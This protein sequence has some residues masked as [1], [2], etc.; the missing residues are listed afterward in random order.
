MILY[1]D[2]QPIIFF[3]LMSQASSL[4]M[5]TSSSRYWASFLGILAFLTE[6]PFAG[7]QIRASLVLLMSQS[8]STCILFSKNLLNSLI[9][10]FLV[11]CFIYH[12][13]VTLYCYFT[14]ISG[15]NKLTI[16]SFSTNSSNWIVNNPCISLPN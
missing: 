10:W 4:N 16:C 12:C 2:L 5:S 14:E 7:T 11:S 1:M 6:L 13:V 8:F 3:F 9:L 15:E